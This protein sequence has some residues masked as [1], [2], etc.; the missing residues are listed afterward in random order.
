MTCFQSAAENETSKKFYILVKQTIWLRTS[1]SPSANIVVSEQYYGFILLEWDLYSV[2]L[3]PIAFEDI[4]LFFWRILHY[5]IM[6]PQLSKGTS[7]MKLAYQA[8]SP[9]V[10]LNSHNVSYKLCF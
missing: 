5:W 2:P 6:L 8:S 3:L 7:L 10:E 1:V 4:Y 9:A